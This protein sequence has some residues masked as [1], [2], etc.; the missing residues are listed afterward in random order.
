[1]NIPPGLPASA[2]AGGQPGSGVPGMPGGLP[3]GGL[4]GQP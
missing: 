3:S 4:P 1:M 2:P